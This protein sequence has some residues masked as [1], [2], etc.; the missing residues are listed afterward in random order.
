MASYGHYAMSVC[1]GVGKGRWTESPHAFLVGRQGGQHP[2]CLVHC[3]GILARSLHKTPTVAL[4]GFPCIPQAAPGL[5]EF[6]GHFPILKGLI[7]LLLF[8]AVL[9]GQP[10]A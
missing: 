9:A 4:A 1:L 5:L 2:R 6:S 7:T 8:A 3:P 10:G